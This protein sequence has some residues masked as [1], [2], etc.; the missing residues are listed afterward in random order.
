MKFRNIKEVNSYLEYVEDKYS[1]FKILIFNK[2]PY[3]VYIR[4]SIVISMHIKDG[5]GEDSFPAIG[6]NL[7][8]ILLTI[9]SG[10]SGVFF[11]IKK[12][13]VRFLFFESPRRVLGKEPYLSP[14]YKNLNQKDYIRLCYTEKWSYDEKD[15]VY[16]NFHKLTAITIAG[17]LSPF[18]PLFMGLER[19]KIL[20]SSTYELLGSCN[21]INFYKIK[22]FE[23]IYWYFFFSLMLK[24]TKPKKVFIVSNTFFIPLI[25]VC[26]KLK[27]ETVEVQHGVISKYVPNYNLPNLNRSYFFPN[28]LLLLGNGWQ[29]VEEFFPKGTSTRVLGSMIFP[30]N[31]GRRQE[32]NNEFILFISQKTSRK[33]FF[34]FMRN[35]IDVLKK[36]KIVYKLH[37]MEYEDR[38]IISNLIPLMLREGVKFIESEEDTATLI[39][40]AICQIG[41]HSTALLEGVQAGTLTLILKTPLHYYLDFLKSNFVKRVGVDRFD[42]LS[43]L[44]DAVKDPALDNNIEYFSELDEEVINEIVSI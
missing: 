8:K 7:K 40:G 17:I 27:I 36:Y 2:I 1:V 39:S 37:P 28:Q 33:Y 10:F 26:D 42:E 32:V 24:I 35:N 6:F 13:K 20:K 3:W 43:E 5:I 15:V 19:F 16:L 21:R 11:I 14:L 18:L 38:N 30:K 4:P 31:S 25:A 23:C 29:F 41:C 22:Y 12:R 44:L 9:R 34:E